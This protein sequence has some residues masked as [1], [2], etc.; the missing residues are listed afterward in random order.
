MSS[1]NIT[2]AVLVVAVILWA[3]A[4]PYVFVGMLGSIGTVISVFVGVGGGVGIVWFL[5]GE[6]IWVDTS[7]WRFV[8]KPRGFRSSPRFAVGNDDGDG[9]RCS[10]C[11]RDFDKVHNHFS[12]DTEEYCPDCSQLAKVVMQNYED[13]FETTEELRE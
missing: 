5:H 1:Y 13:W 6:R 2:P 10:G 4:V 7:A 12:S 8:F 3:L 11:G 9:V